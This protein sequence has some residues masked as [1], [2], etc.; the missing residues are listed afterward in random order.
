M[1]ITILGC[2]TSGGVPRIG[3]NWGACDPAE[4]RNRRRRCSI[5]VQ[6]DETN[7]L[8]DT[9]PDLREQLL[10]ADIATLDAVLWTHEH[11]DQLNGIDDLRVVVYNQR[12]RIPAYAAPHCLAT[13][14]QRFSYCFV[15]ETVYPPI[16]EPHEIDGDFNI[17][18]VR[19]QSFTQDHGSMTSLGFRFNDAAYSNDCVEL[20]EEAFE[21]LRGVRLWIVDCMRYTPHPT[22]AHLDRALEW[23]ARVR[24]E[25]AV[26]TNMHIDLDYATL[27]R[28][29]PQGVEPAYDG[30]V[31]D[32]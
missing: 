18:P 14:S 8:V 5:L 6:Q 22:H 1:R 28:E 2:G 21:T 27:K 24:P 7:I 19:I 15:Q 25:R 29:L 31:L 13:I 17:G 10:D 16:L 11:A 20:P 12:R 26:L 9:S 3:N 4:P 30:M 23:I 32:I